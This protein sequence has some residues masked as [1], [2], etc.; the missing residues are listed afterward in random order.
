[1]EAIEEMERRLVKTETDL[2]KSKAQLELRQA[3]IH[4]MEAEFELKLESSERRARESGNF[5]I[6]PNL[7]QAMAKAQGRIRNAE[8]DRH[9]DLLRN[10]Y[11][12]L[13]SVWD[14]CREALSD[15]GVAVFQHIVR[16]EKPIEKPFPVWGMM[17]TRLV[18][19][20]S[21]E[22]FEVQVEI[23]ETLMARRDGP[24]VYNAQSYGSALTYAKR[25]S[26]ALAVGV[27]SGDDEDDGNGASGNDQNNTPQPQNGRGGSRP[28]AGRKP[29]QEQAGNQAQAPVKFDWSKEPEFR[30]AMNAISPNG[31]LEKI[32]FIK[33]GQTFLDLTG[34]QVDR[35]KA[36]FESFKSK[37][38]EHNNANQ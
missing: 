37:T 18:H 6:G 25:Y 26:L 29:S 27:A 3:E 13:S 15:S 20:E 9:N 19:G 14:A 1:M 8:K 35:I 5:R 23:R 30:E 33:P 28:N 16:L 38:A 34:P 21:G 7:A 12:T 4:R 31:F 17:A 11:S 24:G 36:D 22:Q 10:S 32:S 2:A